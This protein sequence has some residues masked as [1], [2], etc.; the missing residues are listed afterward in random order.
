MKR[1]H[2]VMKIPPDRIQHAGSRHR[3]KA[4]SLFFLSGEFHEKNHKTTIVII[5]I[6]C[7]HRAPSSAI[8]I[9]SMEN[10]LTNNSVSEEGKYW[11]FQHVDNSRIL[12][13]K[14]KS[15]FC[16]AIELLIVLR[17]CWWCYVLTTKNKVWKIFGP[18]GYR[19][20][21]HT[22]VK[23]SAELAAFKVFSCTRLSEGVSFDRL[24]CTIN[25]TTLIHRKPRTFI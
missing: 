24:V 16:C 10:E 9:S 13:S 2:F 5:I 3:T 21:V 14:K 25:S 23:K 20:L 12:S 15:S 17:P 22:M 4:S 7:Q 19:R 8:P 11:K 18:D 1:C 6:N